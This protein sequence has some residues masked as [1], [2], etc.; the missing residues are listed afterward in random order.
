MEDERKKSWK[1]FSTLFKRESIT[2]KISFK[3]ILNRKHAFRFALN[4]DTFETNL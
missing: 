1:Y 3:R 2:V 4:L